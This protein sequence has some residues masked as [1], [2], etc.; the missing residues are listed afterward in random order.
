MGKRVGTIS[1][2][3]ARNSSKGNPMLVVHVDLG[4]PFEPVVAYLLNTPQQMWQIKQLLTAVGG[5]EVE[6]NFT[7]DPQ[8]LFGKQVGMELEKDEFNGRPQARVR[9]WVPAQEISP[10]DD[11]DKIQTMLPPPNDEPAKPAPTND[12]DDVPTHPANRKRRKQGE[13]WSAMKD[14]VDKNNDLD[15]LFQ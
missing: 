1:K 14:S 10:S 2:A 8:Q 7:L 15:A 6:S 5:F 13:D 9:K 3:E 4:K 12:D 11:D